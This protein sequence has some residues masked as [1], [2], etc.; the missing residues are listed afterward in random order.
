MTHPPRLPR[1]LRALLRLYPSAHRREYGEEMLGVAEVR[2]RRAGG[3]AS[4]TIAAAWDLA[5]AAS[6]V[7][8]DR[9]GRMMMGMVRGWGL[10]SRFVARSLWR[11]RGFVATAIA[12]LACAVAVNTTVFSYVRGTL[13]AEPPYPNPEAVTIVW[14]SNVA[15]GQLRDVISGSN[16]IDL[17]DEITTLDPVAAIHNDGVY[18]MVDG[19]PEVLD[20]MGVTVDFLDVLGVQPAIGRF[21]DERERYSGGLE[22]VVVTHAFWRDR[23]ESD[24]DVVG[25]TLPFEAGARTIIGVLPEGFEFISPTP[26][27]VP[28]HD[29][30]LAADERMRIH[31]H[32]LG[33]LVPGVSVAEVNGELGAIMDGIVTEY[34]GYDGWSFL[35][36]PLHRISVAAVRPV[37][38][39]LTATVGLVLLVALVNLATLFRIRA[40]ARAGEIAVRAALGAGRG[41]LLRV[42]VIETAGLAIV[43][44]LIGLAAAPFILRAVSGMLPVWVAIP[45]SAARI[46]VLLAVLDPGVAA[47]AFG[48]AVLGS[49]ALTAPN[50]VSAIRSA[51]VARMAGERVHGGMRSTK[52]LVGVELA[53]ATVLCIGAALTARSAANLLS[54]DVG[55]E[56]EGL[57]TLYFGDVGDRSPADRTEYFRQVVDQV[58]RIPGVRRAGVT[59]YVDF[60]AEDDYARIYF[61]DRAFEPLRDVREEWRRV[62]EGLFEAAG[63]EMVRGRGFVSTDFESIP[64]VA[65]VNQAFAT[66][67]YEGRSPLG[68]LLS[69]HNAG[70]RDMEIVGVVEDVRSLG[71]AAPPPPMLYVPYQGDPR[72]TQGLYVRVAGDP[73]S[74]ASA[75]QDAIWSVDPSQPLRNVLPMAELVD[76]WVAIPRATRSLVLVLAALACLLASVGVF[77]VVAYAVKTRRSEMGI[78]LAL[79]ASAERLEAD[80]IKAIAPVIV[81]GL[82]SGV[83]LGALGARAARAILYGVSPLDPLSIVAAIGAMGA[84]ALVATYLPARRA[85]RISPTEV[86]RAE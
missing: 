10:D 1:L 45:D 53:L 26:L 55:V 14:G 49:L 41:A 71:P 82:G 24:P 48:G 56:A 70:Y 27:Y 62:D 44:A 15:D 60:M 84:A 69:T 30:V 43:G 57:L 5:W 86:I 18:L 83:A 20:A 12:V 85:A 25:T 28:I 17:Q 80:Q 34:P 11:S 31:Y 61:L 68:E 22:T 40:Y 65:V 42:L 64:R 39:I 66:K 2:W 59:G 4:A 74:Y 6:G 35:A 51:D 54:Q 37:I 46:P 50:F 63:T 29:D 38:L 7:W 21:F 58:E 77:G 81:L 23:L 76:A 52:L 78:R 16:Y 36:E 32:V 73:M 79:G 13:L 9:M 47:V 33:R 75:V 19:R 72:G 67:H 8:H 3:T